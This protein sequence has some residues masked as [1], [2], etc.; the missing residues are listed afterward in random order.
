MG[1]V[2]SPPVAVAA[3]A[4]VVLT[5]IATLCVGWLLDAEA[6]TIGE[7]LSGIGTLAAVVV[8]LMINHHEHRRAQYVEAVRR[9]QQERE[10]AARVNAW[11]EP[12]L[13]GR[14]Q[15]NEGSVEWVLVVDN[16]YAAPIYDWQAGIWYLP[17]G[18]PS[19]ESFTPSASTHGRLFPGRRIEERFALGW[20]RDGTLLFP[21]HPTQELRVSIMWRDTAGRWWL[22]YGGELR[23]PA[24]HQW[25]L[26]W[27]VAT[28]GETD[29]DALSYRA[30][31]PPP[32]TAA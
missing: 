1:D 22:R 18:Q 26:P 30:I 19:V 7:W 15:M 29:I 16:A 10:E 32:V 11:Y 17:P 9:N 31:G 20:R 14:G 23:G 24:D 3:I 5:M 12:D 2:G 6:G 25:P 28:D 21:R 8:A 4:F 13:D 27:A